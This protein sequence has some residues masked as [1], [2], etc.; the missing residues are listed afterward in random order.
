MH[1]SNSPHIESRPPGSAFPPSS[2]CPRPLIVLIITSTTITIRP[3]PR[4]PR[5]SFIQTD[6]PVRATAATEFHFPTK[7]TFRG[8][9]PTLVEPNLAV[10]IMTRVDVGLGGARV[11]FLGRTIH[12]FF[13]HS[14]SVLDETYK[15]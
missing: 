3:P 11:S 9:G 4:R 5:S 12:P 13:P 2:R 14:E 1:L 10:R 15:P 6:Q 8:I 7:P